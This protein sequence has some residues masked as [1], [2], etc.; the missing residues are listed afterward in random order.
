MSGS[1]FS[2]SRLR[3]R[4]A[5]SSA[6]TRAAWLGVD[7]QH[8][9]VEKAAALR[10]RA[11]EQP[12]HRRH[13]P[14]HAEMIG[15][16]GSRGDRLAVDPALARERRFVGGRFDAGAEGREPQRAVDLGRNRP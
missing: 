4:S 2:K 12:V 15:E 14:H 16:R 8:Q 1:R 5:R 3:E 6:E 7:R 10:C 11:H 13:Q 9:S